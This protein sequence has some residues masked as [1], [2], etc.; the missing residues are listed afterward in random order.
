MKIQKENRK[1]YFL[2]KEGITINGRKYNYDVDKIKDLSLS[3]KMIHS[4]STVNNLGKSY[5]L[6]EDIVGTIDSVEEKNGE[7][8]VNIKIIKDKKYYENLFDNSNM[9][10]GLRA[11]SK[12]NEIIKIQSW[13]LIKGDEDEI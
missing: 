13:D 10:I 7:I 2:F 8:I 1:Y 4:N 5:N 9:S 11:F 12:D 6:L 3:Q